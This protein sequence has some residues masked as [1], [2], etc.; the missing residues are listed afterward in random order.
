MTSTT[1]PGKSAR[2]AAQEGAYVDPGAG[3]E[4]GHRLVEQ[5]HLRIEGERPRQRH[6]LGLAAGELVRAPVGETSQP[7]PL[8]PLLRRRPGGRPAEAARP[9][10]EGDVVAHVEVREQP[11]VLEDHAG[12]ALLGGHERVRAAASRGRRPPTDPARRAPEPGDRAQQGGLARPRS[13]RARRAP[14]RARTSKDDVELEARRGGRCP[15]SA[16]RRCAARRARAVGGHADPPAPT[17]RPRR[18]N[19]TATETASSTSERA[20][21][22]VR[23]GLHREVDRQRH[24]AGHALEV[25]GE[26]DRGAEL[27]ERAGPAQH[28]AGHQRRPDQRQRDAA[29]DGEPAGAEGRGGLVVPLVGGAERPLDRDHQE[30]HRHERLGD[31]HRRRA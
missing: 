4:G 12:P 13:A 28:R 19:S 27:A 15:R 14:R 9:G 7:E 10:G 24:R 11:V 2:W 31:D 22:R 3:V 16:G 8:E 1:G 18:A 5:Q 17:Q 21:G 23:V 6:P 26:G 20:S 29:E 25:A 30:R